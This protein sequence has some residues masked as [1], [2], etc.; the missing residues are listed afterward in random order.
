MQSNKIKENWLEMEVEKQNV[1]YR[2]M[3]HCRN[4][5]HH[6]MFITVNSTIYNE[7]FLFFI[8]L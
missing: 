8:A 7:Y 3:F 6:L 1:N 4:S 2:I 5:V